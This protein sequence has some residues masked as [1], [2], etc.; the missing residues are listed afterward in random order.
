MLSDI[1]ALNGEAP[2]GSPTAHGPPLA[3]TTAALLPP[4][5]DRPLF[6]GDGGRQGSS[7]LT[8]P[9]YPNPPTFESYLRAPAV[10]TSPDM[11][12]R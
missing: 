11:A 4:A 1:W 3:L 8:L 5:V 6:S 2:R 12:T 9:G 10:T 7:S